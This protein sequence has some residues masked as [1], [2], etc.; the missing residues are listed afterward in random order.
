MLPL[1][2]Y[3]VY[4]CGPI[5][6]CTDEECNDWRTAAKTALS[7]STLDPMRRDYR[8]REDECVNEIV[9]L[10]KLDITESHCLLVNHPGPS[11]GTDMEIF[12][13]WQ[14][15]KPVVVVVPEG[16]RI[17]PWLRYHSNHITSSF[18][19]AYAIVRELAKEWAAKSA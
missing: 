9:E 8:G 14:L 3:V 5:N 11:T 18:E 10:D 15:N 13:A 6:G 2:N 4:L 12:I 7:T 19:A 16:A 1:C 17:S